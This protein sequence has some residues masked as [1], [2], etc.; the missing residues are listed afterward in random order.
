MRPL[1]SVFL[2]S[3]LNTSW[4]VSANGHQRPS[5][6][7][8][9]SPSPANYGSPKHDR[10]YDERRL[11]SLQGDFKRD[12]EFDYIVVGGGTGGNAIG[13]RLAEAGFHVAIVEAGSLYEDKD[14]GIHTIPGQDIIG[15]GADANDT[16]PSDVDWKF[17]TEPQP[18]ANHRSVH[19]ARGKCLGG[20]S[21]LNFMIYHRAT[22]GTYDMWADHVGDDSYR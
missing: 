13:V 9:P 15:I 11:G 20:S 21:A 12:R 22:R 18:G 7:T 2:V 1:S 10:G 6:K 19:F 5:Y 4:L 8:N 17:Q 16:V 3:L 14:K